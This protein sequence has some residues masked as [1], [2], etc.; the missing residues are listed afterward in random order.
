MAKKIQII[1]IIIFSILG[2]ILSGTLTLAKYN[3]D[4]AAICGDDISN[5]CNTVQNSNYSS[6]LKLDDSQGNT[7][8]QFPLSLAGMFFYIIVLGLSII[9]LKNFNNKK[10]T[11]LL[12]VIFVFGFIGVF[13]SAYYTWIQAYKIEAFCKYCLISAFDSLMIFLLLSSILFNKAKGF[14]KKNID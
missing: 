7:K 3:N 12:Y 9:L 11:K 1:L 5:S 2:I 13:T 8:F 4:I 6:L 14:Y 10:Y